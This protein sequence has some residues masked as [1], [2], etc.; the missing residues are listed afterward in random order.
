M[1][2]ATLL[3]H[4]ALCATGDEQ[5]RARAVLEDSSPEVREAALGRI[6]DPAVLRLLEE[7][8]EGPLL[9]TV[10]WRL[11]EIEGGR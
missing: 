8:L 7:E 11:R 10:R 4:A 9:G 1:I 3:R 5:L 2:D 6:D